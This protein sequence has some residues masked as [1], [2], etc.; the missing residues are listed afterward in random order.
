MS[1]ADRAGQARRSLPG[2]AAHELST[3][4]VVLLAHR[5]VARCHNACNPLL[6]ALRRTSDVAE[7]VELI[8]DLSSYSESEA[9]SEDSPGAGSVFH[10]ALQELAEGEKTLGGWDGVG[11]ACITLSPVAFCGSLLLAPTSLPHSSPASAR[12]CRSRRR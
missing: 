8:D 7:A 3:C 10:D 6:Q 9:G 4:D 11:E 12:S 2:S 1:E 5:Q